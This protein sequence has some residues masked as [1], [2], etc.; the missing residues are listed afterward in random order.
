MAMVLALLI[1]FVVPAPTANAGGTNWNLVGWRAAQSKWI[2]GLL[3]AYAEDDWVPYRL[4]AQGFDSKD[5]ELVVEH[6]YLDADGEFGIDAAGRWFIGPIVSGSTP[7]G[8]ATKDYEEGSGFSVSVPVV[9]PLSNGSIIE[10]TITL[11]D[12]TATAL[13]GTDFALYWEAHLSATGKPNVSFPTTTVEYGSSFWNGASLHTHT[14]VTGKQDVPIKTPV[15]VFLDLGSITVHKYDLGTLGLAGATFALWIEGELYDTQVLT[16]SSYT[17]TD[18]AAGT[19]IVEEVAAPAG[20]ELAVPPSR[21]VILTEAD[22]KVQD[23][24]IDFHNSPIET[25]PGTITVYKYSSEDDGG[26]IDTATFE[27]YEDTDGDGVLDAGEPKRQGPS[28]TTGGTVV[29]VNLLAGDYLVLETVAPQGY[30]LDGVNPRAV[31]LGYASTY[32][33]ES[34][35]LSFFNDPIETDLG[36]ITVYKRTNTGSPLSGA[37][38]ALYKGSVLRSDLTLSGSS[39]TW[40]NLE[41]GTY[42]VT[43][44]SAPSGWVR[45]APYSQTVTL[46]EIEGSVEDKSVTFYND[47]REVDEPGTLT[48]IKLTNEGQPLTGA[49]FALYRGSS[50][51]D[52]RTL[53]GNTHKWSNLDAGTYTVVETSAPAGWV[54]R[55]ASKSVSVSEGEDETVTF[56]NDPLAKGSITVIK[57]NTANQPLNGATFALYLGSTKLDERV[58][59]GNTYTWS[60]LN[61]GTYTV[62]E[63]AAPAGYVKANPDRVTVTLVAGATT[64]S[65][66]TVTFRNPPAPGSITVVK[67]VLNEADGTTSGLSGVTF[68]LYKPDTDGTLLDQRTLAGNEYTWSNLEPGDYMVVEVA[69]PNRPDGTP[70]ELADPVSVT[71][72]AGQ[73]VRVEIF[74]SLPLTGAS[75][76]PQFIVGLSMLGLGFAVRR[77]RVF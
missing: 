57:L 64:I 76:L 44:V 48:V 22:Q 3:W 59:T 41:A 58:L 69:A 54:I 23:I 9:K 39:H 35:S 52:E 10:Y 72:P 45:V 17:W 43:E 1:T 28:T 2:G 19:Y 29:F 75:Y 5:K 20:Y 7:I 70:F 47:P 50:K 73:N 31:T 61:A 37:R 55:D 13:D 18:L 42:T 8:D 36:S 21:E 32:V 74:N 77:R 65:S 16:G 25:T 51:L 67:L 33:V 26:L 34:K 14:S 63:V 6:D 66:E 46:N 15:S 12:D 38:F 56:Y 60:N 4:V 49:T 53:T 40:S 24:S 71:V 62:V 68:A 30:E 11:D 27:L